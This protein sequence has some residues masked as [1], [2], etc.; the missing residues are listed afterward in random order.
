M[1][2]LEQIRMNNDPNSPDR[3]KAREAL[4]KMEQPRKAEKVVSQATNEDG[5]TTT[6]IVDEND[7]NW[8]VLTGWSWAVKS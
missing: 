5:V 8:A 6:G 1:T 4:A 2:L 7:E 3:I